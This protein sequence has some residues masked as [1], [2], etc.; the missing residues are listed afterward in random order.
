[1]S[2]VFHES[3]PMGGAAGEAYANTLKSPGMR[4]EHVLAREAIQNSV[5]ARLPDV[6]KV[7]VRFVSK[8]V[9]GSAKKKFAEAASLEDI[10]ARKSALQLQ[11]PNCLDKLAAASVPLSLLYV[12]DFNTEG[13]SGD[14]HD[15]GSNFFRLL[16]SLGDRSKARTAQGSGGSYG[17]GK[18]VYSSSSA[19]QTIFAYTRFRNTDSGK[20]QSRLF[21]CGYYATHEF[22]RSQFS[23]RAWL[24]SKPRRDQH[25]RLIVDPLVDESADRLAERLGFTAR[26]GTETGTTILVIDSSMDSN[27]IRIGIED[28][29]WPRLVEDRL[30]VEVI[31]AEGNATPPRPK[32]RIDL[33]PFIESYDIAQQRAVPQAGQQKFARLNKSHGRELGCCGFGVVPLVDEG[34]I[35]REDRANTVALIRAPL[36]VVAYQRFSQSAPFVIGS[37]VASDEVDQQLKLSEPPAHDKWDPESGNLRDATGENG[38]IVEAVLSRV[39]A[40]LRRF[41]AEA[42]P[43]APPKQKR[44]SVLERALA[45]YFKSPGTGKEPPEPVYTPLHL[46]FDKPP[47]PKASGNGKLRIEATFSV[48]LDERSDE[49]AVQL[50]LRVA[51]PIVE[52][53][54]Q[55][56]DEIPLTLTSRGVECS[57][58]EGD[59]AAVNFQLEKGENARFSVESA[60]YDAS[61]TVRLR[62]LVERLSGAEV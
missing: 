60:P 2:W 54:Q 4:P 12:E 34:P 6:D 1:M 10:A 61:W 59:P 58:V 29:W 42:A 44:L 22:K 5:D 8:V 15:K 49:D 45:S 35:V 33:R 62:P 20:T 43:P 16:L 41:Q 27:E 32:K 14:A 57:P 36:M 50:Q 3:E 19:I 40:N 52:D 23:G 38:E 56:G 46:E 18:S 31:D 25:G 47:Q 30:D 51:L 26:K 39:R 53:A 37:Y 9:K 48:W 11:G 7:L 21:G 17:F 55:E 24:G 13:L 28:W